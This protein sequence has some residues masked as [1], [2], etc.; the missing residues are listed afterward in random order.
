MKKCVKISFTHSSHI[1]ILITSALFIPI[2]IRISKAL[3]EAAC[4][5]FAQKY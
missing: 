2:S 4:C 3:I 1:P 5:Q